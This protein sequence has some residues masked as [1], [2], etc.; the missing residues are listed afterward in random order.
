MKKRFVKNKVIAL[1][2][3]LVLVLAMLLFASGCNP[4]ENTAENL[5]TDANPSIEQKANDQRAE[6]PTKNTAVSSEE[7]SLTDKVSATSSKVDSVEK[8]TAEKALELALA[9]A[10]VLKENALM[11]R[12]EP[13]F[14]KGK[15]IYEV[16]FYSAGYDYDYDIEAETGIIIRFEKE[17]DD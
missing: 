15:E 17:R 3:A 7:P 9:H 8:I 5:K 13:D 4:S 11:D 16:D 12:V 6:S 10:G 2:T 14:E 1:S